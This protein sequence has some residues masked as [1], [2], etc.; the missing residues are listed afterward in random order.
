MTLQ[1]LE[2]FKVLAEVKHYTNA[3]KILHI[4]QPSLSYSMTVLEEELG[5]ALFTKTGKKIDLSFA[6]KVLYDYVLK[7][8]ELL[9]EGIQETKEAGCSFNETINIGYIYSMGFSFLPVIIND[10]YEKFGIERANFN[11]VQ[12]IHEMLVNDLESNKVDLAIIGAPKQ[13]MGKIQI[14]EQELFA[15]VNREHPLA[16]L[17]EI[18]IREI[19]DEKLILTGSQSGLRQFLDV[20]FENLEIKPKVLFDTEE[21]NAIISHVS[22]NKV[23]GILPN[24]PAIENKNVKKLKIINPNFTRKIY[25]VWLKN[26]KLSKKVKEFIKFVDKYYRIDDK[27]ISI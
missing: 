19:V 10:Y 4:S 23:V 21:C 12:N 6:G 11:F 3:S 13:N 26:K 1:Q 15:L 14:F 2:Y 16:V 22:L 27:N 9:E 18:D 17:D 5:V 24:I 7:V 20:A 25:L 8:F